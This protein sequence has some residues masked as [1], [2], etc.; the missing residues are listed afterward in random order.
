MT[1]T[2]A[3]TSTESRTH[4]CLACGRKLT[5]TLGPYGKTCERKIRQ[6]LAALAATG[7]Y[8]PAQV[9]S[10]A[11]LL[12]DGG[13]VAVRETAKNGTLF[14]AVSSDG[15]DIHPVTVKHCGCDAGKRGKTGCY[16]R[17]L[18]R[19]LRSAMAHAATAKRSDYD[20]AV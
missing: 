16:H 20:K 7:E 11:D 2:D 15:D 12:E 9:D 18:A 6:A 3:M 19:A 14:H 4:R 8:T 13:M 1:G 5:V 10:A 17:L